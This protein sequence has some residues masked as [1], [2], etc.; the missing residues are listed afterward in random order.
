MSASNN[1]VFKV[2]G[3]ILLVGGVG[4]AYWGYQMSGAFS[5]KIS[6]SLSGAL[7]DAV[8]YRYIGGAVSAVVG[9]FLLIKK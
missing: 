7:P 6:R 2:L 1:T 8:M 9:L 4:V 5:A 3:L